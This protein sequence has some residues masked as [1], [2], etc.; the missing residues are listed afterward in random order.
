MAGSIRISP[1]IPQY[2]VDADVVSQDFKDYVTGT[3]LRVYRYM[4]RAGTPMSMRDVQRGLD[5][6]SPSVAEYHIKKLVRAGLVQEREDGYV[7]DRVIFE[8][9]IRIRRT[10]IPLQTAYA[11]FFLSTM[12]ILLTVFRP[13]SI[14][15]LYFFALLVNSAAVVVT[16][17]EAAKTYAATRGA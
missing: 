9:V 5:L 3:T 11:A 10:L 8:N 12:A 2:R 13:A 1:A 17:Y 4:Y 16:V 15:S 14:T 7:V 6:S